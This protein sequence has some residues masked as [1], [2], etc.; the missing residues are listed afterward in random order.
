MVA[1]DAD[2]IDIPFLEQLLYS[3][4]KIYHDRASI[5]SLKAPI[6]EER[7]GHNPI[8]ISKL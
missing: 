2:L 5:G 8:V 4:Q 1:S 7:V 3:C 6:D